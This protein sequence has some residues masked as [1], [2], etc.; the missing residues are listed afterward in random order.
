[1]T[2]RFKTV[3][4]VSFSF[5]AIT[6]FVSLLIRAGIEVAILAITFKIY[7]YY[8]YYYYYDDDDDVIL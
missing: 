8:Y 3:I 1:M 5:I 4:E 2:S 7:L 6:G